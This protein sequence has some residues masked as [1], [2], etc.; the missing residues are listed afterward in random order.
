MCVGMQ[1]PRIDATDLTHTR[2]KA[3]SLV[4]SVSA[5]LPGKTKA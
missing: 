4:V 3:L 2:E 5:T 1:R